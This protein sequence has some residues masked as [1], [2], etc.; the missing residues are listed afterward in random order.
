MLNPVRVLLFSSLIFVAAAKAEWVEYFNANNQVSTVTY[1]TSSIKRADES[2]YSVTIFTN[3]KMMQS[4]ELNKR[5]VQFQSKSETQ[6]FGCEGQDF[7]LGDYELYQARD[8][9]GLKTTVT[10]KE[11]IW[12][13]IAPGTLQMDLLH[14]FCATR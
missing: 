14:K 7:A 2:H 12:N 10:Q 6:I 3:Y 1:S 5:K 4:S 13:P 9:L 8:A 11:L